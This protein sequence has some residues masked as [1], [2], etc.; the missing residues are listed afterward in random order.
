MSLIKVLSQELVNQIA[1]GEVVERPAS[2]V[3]ELV[4]NSIDSS[5]TSIQV[6]IEEGGKNLIKVTDN[7]TGISE[8]DLPLTIVPHATSKIHNEK[9]L[10][11]IHTMG[12][13]GEALASIASISE[14][15]IS[16]KQSDSLAA[17]K[18]TIVDGKPSIEPVA[19]PTG[20]TVEVKDLF[21]NVPA[22]QKYLKK[23]TTEFQKISQL[24]NQLSLSNPTECIK[25]IHNQKVDFDY[26]KTTELRNRITQVFGVDTAGAMLPIFFESKEIKISGF[27]GKPSISRTTSQHQYFIVNNRCIQNHLFASRIKAAY[28]TML[29]E[30]KKPTFIVKIDLPPE[31]IDV[32]VHP[33]KLEI[34]FEDE[35]QMMSII[36]QSVKESLDNNSLIPKAFTE[37]KRYMSDAFPKS[38]YSSMKNQSS[39]V[40]KDSSNFSQ[41]P[42]N[43]I[44][45]A[46]PFS[47]EILNDFSPAESLSIKE[48]TI[49]IT[50]LDTRYI[51]AK[52][53]TGLLLID[54]HAA[55]ERV[56]FETLMKE[57]K[58][59]DKAKQSLL[60]PIEITLTSS[61]KDILKNNLSDLQ[62]VGF[63]IEDFG[64]NS[65]VIHA[66]PVCLNKEDLKEV[67]FGVID[68]IKNEIPV[69]EMQGKVEQMLTYM[70]CRSAIKF[71]QKLNLPEMQSLIDQLEKQERPWTCPHGRPTMVMLD[72]NELEKM[73][74]RKK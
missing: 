25:L 32:N 39:F 24:L 27:I 34:R 60:L 26:P 4:E 41:K 65:F 47:K 30:H 12:F 56:R 29:M 42:L 63:E 19:H 70:A 52:N 16:T 54:Q 15:S 69:S 1:A 33:R 38:N 7:G 18:L 53:S 74:G 23:T 2:V 46:L 50:Q 31:K 68:D 45:S 73:F 55:H 10:W 9:D 40:V 8:A 14:L 37:S 66:I 64:E 3:K 5:A 43:N 72:H 71:G 17:N 6:E 67:I 11:N 20:T 57:F 22:R 49:A 13:R 62:N 61:E 28:S 36:Y 44:N 51:V 48:K 58:K 21:Y 59:Q 35:K